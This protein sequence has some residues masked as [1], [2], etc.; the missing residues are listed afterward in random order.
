MMKRREPVKRDPLE[1]EIETALRPG[2]FIDWRM[3]SSFTSELDRVTAQ[4][5]QFVSSD[6]ERAVSLYES[7]L[8]GCYE[9]AEEIDDD[10]YFGDFVEGLYCGWVKA[11]QAAGADPDKTVSLLLDRMENDPYGYAFELERE[12][13]KVL[14]TAGLAAFERAV[15]TLYEAKDRAGQARR[16]WGEVLR[17]IYARQQDVPAYVAV[18]HETALSAKDCLVLSGMHQEHNPDEALAWVERGLLLDKETPNGS[19]AGDDLAKLKR[20][21]LARLGRADVALAEAWAEFQKVPSKYRYEELMRFV[22]KAEVPLWR[23]KALDAAERGDLRSRIELL[24]ETQETER[25]VRCIQEMGDSELESLSHYITE[26]VA[27]LLAEP[28]P[29][30]AARVFRAMGMRILCAKKS[31][32]YH[33]ALENFEGAKICYARANLGQKWE[34]VVAQVRREHYRKV[35]FMPGFERLVAGQSPGQKPSY[36]D[37]ARKRWL[38]RG[39]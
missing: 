6:P 22:P 39:S 27:E 24:L 36:L 4:I 17:V 3:G 25:L 21:L 5:D 2:Q 10:G 30:L 8:A 35:G 15:R 29:E 18:C 1:A 23:A 16:R 9:K 7:L 33:E 11:R 32:C 37:R 13:V 31:K 38:P 34:A 26:P 12:A 28:H 19:Y 20:E 14:D